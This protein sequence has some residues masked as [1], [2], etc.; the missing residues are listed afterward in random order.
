MR[1]KLI[2]VSPLVRPF[3]R[4]SFNCGKPELNV[5]IRNHALNNQ[6][7]SIGRTWIAHEEKS[8]TILGF[9]TVC[10]SAISATDLPRLLRKKLP[11][12]PVPCVLLARLAV[13]LTSQG[14]GVGKL[15]LKDAIEKTLQI[16]DAIGAYALLVNA[17]DD[18]AK[19]F[20]EYYGFLSLPDQPYTLFLPVTTFKQIL[21]RDA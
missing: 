10:A 16:G 1:T 8:T 7:L 20:Y 4:E 18:E 5:F 21:V 17:K 15:L 9:Y 11:R 19:S 14:R 6:K 3:D 2:C 13:D 12:Y